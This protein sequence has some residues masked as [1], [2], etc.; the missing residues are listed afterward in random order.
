MYKCVVCK[1]R[2]TRKDNLD[3]HSKGACKRRDHR[4][5]TSVDRLSS[6]PMTHSSEAQYKCMVC[7]K[8]FTRKDNLDRHSKGACK[9]GEDRQYISVERLSSPPMTHSSEP[10]R[11]KLQKLQDELLRDMVFYAEYNLMRKRNT[12]FL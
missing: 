9:R 4:Q 3:R 12:L 7:M 1:K 5:Y 2:F 6:P 8:S 10:Q 11:V